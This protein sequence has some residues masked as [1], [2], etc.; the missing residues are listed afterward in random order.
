MKAKILR[1]PRTTIA[2]LTT[3]VA[4]AALAVV[5]ALGQAGD[6]PPVGLAAGVSALGRVASAKGPIAPDVK[7]FAQVNAK[8]LGATVPEIMA[9]VRLLRS[10]LGKHS[11]DVYAFRINGAVCFVLS[12]EGGT[13]SRGSGSSSFAWTIGGGDGITDAGALVGVAADD[14]SA[15]T[16]TVDGKPIAVSLA[17]NIA[18]AELPLDGKLAVFTVHHKDGKETTDTV[19][20]QG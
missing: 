10:G 13:C 6:P 20:L 19:R 8:T 12:G 16:L 14:V 9:Q 7:K 2:L 3:A 17:N 1:N 4:A 11:R 5:V 15:I 18:Y